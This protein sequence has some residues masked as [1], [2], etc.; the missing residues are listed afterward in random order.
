MH[1]QIGRLRQ[2]IRQEESL[3]RIIFVA[4]VIQ[5]NAFSKNLC[6]IHFKIFKE[7]LCNLYESAR[8]D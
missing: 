8:K 1:F 2:P 7:S 3:N 4:L 6:V 5:I